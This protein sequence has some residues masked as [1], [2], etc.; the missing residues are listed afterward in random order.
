MLAIVFL[1]VFV[2][3]PGNQSVQIMPGDRKLQKFDTRYIKSINF[4]PT[5]QA[6]IY[7]FSEEPEVSDI[8]QFPVKKIFPNLQRGSYHYVRYDLY[9]GSTVDMNWDFSSYNLAP[10]ILILQGESAFNDFVK[11]DYIPLLARKYEA[12]VARGSHRFDVGRRDAY[13]FIFY[14]H[15][16][17]VYARG[18][19]TFSVT[20]LTL[21]LSNPILAC[22]LKNTTTSAIPV[23]ER[24]TTL[25][26]KNITLPPLPRTSKCDFDLTHL[27]GSAFVVFDV[28]SKA[29]GVATVFWLSRGRVWSYVWVV[30]GAGVGVLLWGLLWGLGREGRGRGMGYVRVEEGA[31][32]V[33]GPP[34]FR[35]V[36]LPAGQQQPQGGRVGVVLEHRV[37]D[38]AP[39]A[40]TVH[41]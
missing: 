27:S 32:D 24:D 10:N 33:G 29:V 12:N 19:A 21:S 11:G 6:D 31:A 16:S 17:Y 1:V 7:L 25:A 20:S 36:P 23:P 5:Y 3:W 14:S 41:V 26:P 30:G 13:Y 4:M 9:H 15:S 40:Y 38:V 2:P 39:P 8:V 28:D 18:E 22:T 34:V 35:G 37:E